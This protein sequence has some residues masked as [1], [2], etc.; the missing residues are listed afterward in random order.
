V[1]TYIY[2]IRVYSTPAQQHSKA[3]SLAAVNVSGQDC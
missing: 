2:S 3:T 1:Y